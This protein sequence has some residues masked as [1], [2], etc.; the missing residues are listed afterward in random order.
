M[1]VIINCVLIA[2]LVKFYSFAFWQNTE[3]KQRTAIGQKVAERA[4][5]EPKG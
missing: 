5:S 4:T 2:V 1:F 3:K